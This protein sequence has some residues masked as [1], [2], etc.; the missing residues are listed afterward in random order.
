M[1]T[2]VELTSK[3]SGAVI[4][5]DNTCVIC[6]WSGI[7][8]FPMISP[9]GIMG[10]GSEIPEVEPEFLE[11]KHIFEDLDEIY[12]TADFDALPDKGWV[13]DLG[14]TVVIT[15]DDWN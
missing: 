9:I 14:D 10:D 12:S 15:F 6:N 13:Y 3:E 1:K 11:V 8:G 4:Y 5:D 2:L 7:E